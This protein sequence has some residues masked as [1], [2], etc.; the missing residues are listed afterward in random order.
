MGNMAFD[1]MISMINPQVYT[2]KDATETIVVITTNP[3]NTWAK[4]GEDVYDT[5]EPL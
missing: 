2:G 4:K 5:K 3:N 1:G